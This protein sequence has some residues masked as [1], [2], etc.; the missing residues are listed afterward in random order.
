VVPGFVDG[1]ELA[2]NGLVDGF[3][4]PGNNGTVSCRDFCWGEQWGAIG[5][6]LAAYKGDS[7][8]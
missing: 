1:G 7:I 2:C 3:N 4:K 5:N 8:S 6:C